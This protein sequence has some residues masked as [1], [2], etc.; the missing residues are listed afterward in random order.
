[1]VC[2]FQI[3]PMFV[4]ITFKNSPGFAG[5]FMAALYGGALRFVPWTLCI[6]EFILVFLLEYLAKSYFRSADIWASGR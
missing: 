4:M 1:M 2:P 6:C 5:L 3:L